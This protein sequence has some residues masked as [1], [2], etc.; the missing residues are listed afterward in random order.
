[1]IAQYFELGC[2]AQI[3]RDKF[4][5]VLGVNDF[6]TFAFPFGDHQY[7]IRRVPRKRLKQDVTKQLQKEQQLKQYLQQQRVDP[8]AEVLKQYDLRPAHLKKPILP[9]KPILGYPKAT[10][11]LPEPIRDKLNKENPEWLQK[12]LDKDAEKPDKERRHT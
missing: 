7:I 8:R 3:F 1:M 4:G 12:Y 9:K 2:K 10:P 5:K 6:L 11:P